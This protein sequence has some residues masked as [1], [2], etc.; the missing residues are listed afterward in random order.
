MHS[1]SHKN[2][3]DNDDFE[4][5]ARHSEGT[6]RGTGEIQV[7]PASLEPS[8]SGTESEQD[9]DSCYEDYKDEQGRDY[10]DVRLLLPSP[11]SKNYETSENTLVYRL[12]EVTFGS[13]LA[14]Y[15]LGFIG[16]AATSIAVEA[17]SPKGVASQDAV[18]TAEQSATT[19]FSYFVGTPRFGA[20]FLQVLIFVLISGT[21]AYLTSTMYMRYHLGILTMPTADV[22][23]SRFDFT[24]AVSQAGLFGLSMLVP[25]TFALCVALVLWAG[26]RRQNSQVDWLAEQY[27]RKLIDGIR[28]IPNDRLANVPKEYHPLLTREQRANLPRNTAAPSQRRIQ[29]GG[30]RNVRPERKAEQDLLRN[31]KDK[32]DGSDLIGW[33]RVPK[34]NTIVVTALG[35]GLFVL[36][37]LPWLKG[38]LSLLGFLPTPPVEYLPWIYGVAAFGLCLGVIWHGQEQLIQGSKFIH[39]REGMDELDGAFCD[40]DKQLQRHIARIS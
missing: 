36:P 11:P 2:P 20:V 4:P 27:K 29:G 24:I 37:F 9:V 15:I 6:P 18:G 30:P 3:G 34:T 23:L 22:E 40:L 10:K 32:I 12:S 8:A 31:V 19:I 25:Q 26:T 13:I 7:G 35:V 33:H 39:N 14:T 38:E 21:F 1:G 5:A 16:F 17:N 28:T